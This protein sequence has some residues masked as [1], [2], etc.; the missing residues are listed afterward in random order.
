MAAVKRRKPQEPDLAMVFFMAVVSSPR[1]FSLLALLISLDLPE[2]PVRKKIPPTSNSSYRLFAMLLLTASGTRT[3][4]YDRLFVLSQCER[5][6]SVCSGQSRLPTY[7]L[8]V[9]SI[10]LPVLLNRQ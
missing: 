1:Y 10:L 2:K 8:P 9:I 3:F 5:L 7:L 6:V 4:F